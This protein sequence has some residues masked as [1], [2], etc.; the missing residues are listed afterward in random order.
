MLRPVIRAEV[1]REVERA[2][3]RWRWAP[4]PVVA[5]YLGISEEAVRQRHQ[6]GKLPSKL[7]EGRVVIDLDALDRQIGR[8]R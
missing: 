7:V 5:E 3:L 6:A 4:V 8:L 1:A 2:K